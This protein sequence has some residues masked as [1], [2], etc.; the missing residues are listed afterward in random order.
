LADVK[1]RRHLRNYL[2]DKRLQLQYVVVVALVSAFIA[3]GLGFLLNRQETFASDTIIRSMQDSGMVEFLGPEGV[4]EVKDSLRSQDTSQM[5][6]M[7]VV[8]VGLMLV[9]SAY[10]IL[11]THQVAGPLYKISTYFDR[12]TEGKLPK[13]Y[14]L[15]KGDQLVDFFEKFK[16]MDEALRARTEAEVAAMERFLADCEKAG[17]P[18][19]GDLGHRL[20]ELR[21]LVRQ[22]RE[23]LS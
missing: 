11:M 17:V 5:A 10:M 3:A 20:E 12:I 23:A 2:I 21:A 15:R 16:T 9:L 8:G 22:K 7:I 13:V 4:A 14:N 18:A 1:H 19:Q 6:I